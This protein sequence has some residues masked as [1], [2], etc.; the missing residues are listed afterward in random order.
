MRVLQNG[1]VMIES[2]MNKNAI[3]LQVVLSCLVACGEGAKV[4]TVDVFDEDA[5][6]QTDT[7]LDTNDAPTDTSNNGSDIGADTD[8]AI[9]ACGSLEFPQVATELF[10]TFDDPVHLASPPGSTDIYVVQRGGTILVVQDGRPLG[11][12]FLD[13]S[14]RLT[15]LAGNEQGLLGLAFHPEYASNGRFF[16]FIATESPAINAVE[17]YERS[18]R[19]PLVAN[20]TLV[21]TLVSI[22]DIEWN[23]NG[24]MLQFHNGLLYVG[25]GDGGGGGDPGRTSQNPL[26]L[27]GKILRLDVDNTRGGF[28][29]AGNPFTDPRLG[30]PLVWSIGVRNPWRFAIDDGNIYI[31]D[32]G[33]NL[34]EE[35]N[36]RSVSDANLNY[37]WSAFEG[38]R[39]YN[40]DQSDLVVTHATPQIEINQGSS[41]AILRDACSITGGEVYRGTAIPGLVGVYM[42]GDYCS[43]DMAAFRY[44]EGSVQGLT[45][46]RVSGGHSLG[47]VG[48]SA[49]NSGELYV[50]NHSSGQIRKLI[51]SL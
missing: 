19:N 40:R 27:L 15:R 4:N 3:A 35:L 34:I 32:V 6:V 37:G 24:G 30:S 5:S 21:R 1:V 17:E 47:F 25:T 9:S 44:C 39:T 12:P 51:P 41:T 14:S 46:L 23:H 29:A 20:S 11:T 50:V 33:Q 22:N 8:G 7:A 45:R 28:A 31:A 36:I 49:D 10:G 48:L 16:I 26:N 42:F 18:S 38:T 43:R 2:P 13:V